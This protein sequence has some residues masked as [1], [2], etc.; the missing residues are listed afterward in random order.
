MEIKNFRHKGLK[1]FFETGSKE[2]ILPK[3]AKKTELILE[4]LDAA[5][6]LRD[7][8]FPGANLHKLKGDLQNFLSIHVNGNWVI[9]FRFEN[10]NVYDVDLV[11]YH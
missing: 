9:I 7:L 3:L 10:L 2:G 6:E 4:T 11:D 8:N 5:V 1:K